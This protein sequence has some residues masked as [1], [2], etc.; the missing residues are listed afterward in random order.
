MG[1]LSHFYLQ[2]K[3]NWLSKTGSPRWLELKWSLGWC[4]RCL[5]FLGLASCAWWAISVFWIFLSFF[6]NGFVIRSRVC[7]I[8]DSK[9]KNKNRSYLFEWLS[10][11]IGLLRIRR[12]E[13][14]CVSIPQSLSFAWLVY[15][16]TFQKWV[17]GGFLLVEY[18]WRKTIMLKRFTIIQMTQ[19]TLKICARLHRDK[20]YQISFSKPRVPSFW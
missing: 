6:Q 4:S 11:D 20:S 18:F 7:W 3:T 15:K 5:A 13:E 17:S 19:N 9:K 16:L 12:G 8:A 2:Q 10:V 14:K 1:Q